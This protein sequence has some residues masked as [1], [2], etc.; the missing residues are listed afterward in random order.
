MTREYRVLTALNGTAVPVPRPVAIC[1]DTSVVGAPFY[2]MDYVDGAVLRTSED[3]GGRPHPARRDCCPGASWRCSR[4]STGWTFGSVGLAGFGKPEG[5]LD[6]Q[7]ARWQRQ[8]ELSVTR[9]IR[10]IRRS[11]CTSFSDGWRT[12]THP[13]GECARALLMTFGGSPG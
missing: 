8:W 1:A 5:Y 4:A 11:L 10:A 6:R 3:A 9:E 7:L 13:G 2:L 12:T